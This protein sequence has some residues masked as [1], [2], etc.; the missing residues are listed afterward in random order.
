[1][2]EFAFPFNKER[3]NLVESF[4]DQTQDHFTNFY[5][6]FNEV[7]NLRNEYIDGIL[8]GKY[9]SV[10]GEN[11]ITSDISPEIVIRRKIVD[12]FISGK[13]LLNNFC[14]SNLISDGEFEAKDFLLSKPE[15]IE[16]Y[17][18]KQS[19]KFKYKSGY[20]KIANIAFE[21][22][23]KFLANFMFRRNRIEHDY[24][25]NIPDFKIYVNDLKEIKIIEPIYYEEN[26]FEQI[27]NYYY[28]TLDLI[29][30]VSSYFFGVNAHINSKG[31]ITLLKRKEKADP[32]KFKYRYAIKL[33]VNDPNLVPMLR[34][35]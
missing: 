27:I 7:I 1:M 13:Q 32:S 22:Q 2:S 15:V 31:I 19:S 21:A 26:I 28:S 3:K 6:V 33:H 16:K 11:E 12:F 18:R 29:E 34:S 4:V 20:T 23:K 14:L 17:I 10:S 9:F 30:D 5:D 8:T 25:K 24:G 35:K